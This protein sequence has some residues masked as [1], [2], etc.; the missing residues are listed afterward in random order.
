MVNNWLRPSMHVCVFVCV[1][2]CVYVYVCVCVCVCVC[3][4]V[5]VCVCACVCVC[6]FMR[7]CVYVCMQAVFKITF[8]HQTFS[9]HFCECPDSI[10]FVLTLCQLK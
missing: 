2:V 10:N 8:G 4:Y 6:V 1:C 5:C 9:D 3:V 7:V